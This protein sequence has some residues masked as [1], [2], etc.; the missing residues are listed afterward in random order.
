MHAL[1]DVILAR[2]HARR[3]L[4]IIERLIPLSSF[5]GHTRLRAL[6]T[7]IRIP[8]V[9]AFYKASTLFQLLYR[10][11]YRYGLYHFRSF[12]EDVV[13]GLGFLFFFSPLQ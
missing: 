13:L 1:S 8:H 4:A 3:H 2:G 9:R 10:C 7:N 12:L 5:Y 6:R 11:V